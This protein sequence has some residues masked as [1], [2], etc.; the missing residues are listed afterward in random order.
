MR[1]RSDEPVSAH[2][3]VRFALDDGPLDEATL[4]SATSWGW[5]LAAHNRQQRLTRLQT[6]ELSAGEHILKLAPRDSI[7]LDL[8]AITDNPAMFD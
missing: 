6:F 5:S 8:I 4:L 7:H 3:S 2:D 1:I